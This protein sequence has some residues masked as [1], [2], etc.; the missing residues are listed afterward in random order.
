[1][2]L[3]DCCAESND[4]KLKRQF[5]VVAKARLR[6]VD[7]Y[8]KI[9]DQNGDPVPDAKVEVAW[10]DFIWPL[11]AVNKSTII[12]TDKLGLW[13]FSTNATK[14][15]INNVEKKGFI[16]NRLLINSSYSDKLYNNTTSSDNRFILIV[17]KMNDPT[18]IIHDFLPRRNIY[19]DFRVGKEATF[20]YDVIRNKII[21]ESRFSIEKNS[22][23]HPDLIVKCKNDSS[24][25]SITHKV[26]DEKDGLYI[27]D[28]ILYEAP[29][30][31]YKK[32]KTLSGLK[33]PIDAYIYLVI[34]NHNQPVYV[35]LK[36]RYNTWAN[37]D[38]R[39]IIEPWINPFGSRSFEP[40]PELEPL[41]KLQEQLTQEGVA[42][43]SAGK[44]LDKEA[45]KTRFAEAK[46]EA[47]KRNR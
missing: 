19:V 29:S 17:N 41:W 22:E 14:I 40:D 28:C 2:L 27:S 5:D 6:K 18:F 16:F 12:H 47:K 33:M 7:I 21:N 1:M 3:T 45:F 9:I 10:F 25:W 37:H 8:G 23:L 30:D 35:F 31:G 39:M 32:E 46:A 43:L 4:G 24:G 15:F 26:A 38:S 36:I 11:G 13:N 42:A 44:L 34:R 20:Y